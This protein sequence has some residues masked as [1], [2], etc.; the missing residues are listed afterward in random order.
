MSG[1]YSIKS[2]GAPYFAGLSRG[3][4]TTDLV[5]YGLPSFLVE[6]RLHD[7]PVQYASADELHPLVSFN[8]YGPSGVELL[9]LGVT[10]NGKLSA[11]N[12]NGTTAETPVGRLIAD[13]AWHT[14]QLVYDGGAGT[15]SL[16]LDQDPAIDFSDAGGFPG[17]P[18]KPMPIQDQ[19][20][21]TSTGPKASIF[22]PKTGKSV[23]Y[24][25]A[26]NV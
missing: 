15:G 19:R 3:Y 4:F 21:P 8:E 10:P 5:T 1:Q 23:V 25:P 9:T 14:A 2:A 11:I 7:L 13:G 17:S 16:Q 22:L 12:L 26:A 24:A 6:F 18:I 20:N